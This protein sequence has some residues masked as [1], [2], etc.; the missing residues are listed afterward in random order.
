MVKIKAEIYIGMG[1]KRLT[2]SRE[3]LESRSREHFAFVED[4]ENNVKV[5]NR[6]F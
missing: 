3:V 6:F 2:Y 5:G 4:L 1:I